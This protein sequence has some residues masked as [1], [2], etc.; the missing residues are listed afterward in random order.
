M[1]DLQSPQ[2]TWAAEIRSYERQKRHVVDEGFLRGQQVRVTNADVQKAG[3]VFDPL[4]QRYRDGNVEL[5]QRTL[6][7]R[8]RVTHLNRAQDIQILREQPFDII[9]GD[10]KLDTIAPGVDPAKLSRHPE[11][12]PGNCFPSTA[13]DYNLISNLPFEV[14][15]WARPDRRPRCEKRTGAKQRSVPAHGVKDFNIVSNHYM[16]DHE[17]KSK[18]DRH[19]NL[20]EATHKDAVV[21][22]YDPVL[23]QFRSPH[24]E[25]CARACNDAYDVEVHLRAESHIPPSMKGR[26]SA[27]Y[28]MIAHKKHNDQMLRVHDEAA[29]NRKDRYRNRYITEHNLHAQDVKGD[30]IT[31]V[32]KLN[33]AAPERFEGQTRR[34]YDIITNNHYGSGPKA[35]TIYA[36]Y[37]QQRPTPWEQATAGAGSRGQLTMSTTLPGRFLGTDGSHS[38]APR[39]RRSVSSHG[40]MQNEHYAG[41]AG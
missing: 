4:L 40:R 28:D 18:R 10:S 29:A 3:R 15:H 17:A 1:E 11:G 16:N 2:P 7:E 9:R 8:E 6:E 36:A 30:H 19:L 21:N 37:P 34:G 33:R 22:R 25:D 24:N 32:R 12:S 27:F 13:V 23:Q 39:S 5:K 20:L 26:E 38:G 35:Q 31:N 14:H 41:R